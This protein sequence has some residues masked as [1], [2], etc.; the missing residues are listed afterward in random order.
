MTYGLSAEIVKLFAENKEIQMDIGYEITRSGGVKEYV[1]DFITGLTINSRNFQYDKTI[2]GGD[3]QW[4]KF[5]LSYLAKKKE[6]FD[7]AGN[8]LSP[9]ITVWGSIPLTSPRTE[10]KLYEN[11]ICITNNELDD[12]KLILEFMHASSIP[13]STP[14]EYVISHHFQTAQ[15][16]EDTSM[17]DSAAYRDGTFGRGVV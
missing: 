14:P 17:I 6:Y 4:P 2:E 12:G 8:F 10:L 16:P 15:D 9:V 11:G 13:A 5:T 7:N 3:L 1:T